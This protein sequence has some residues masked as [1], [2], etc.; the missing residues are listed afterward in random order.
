MSRLT[1][2]QILGITNNICDT[3]DASS[4][5][6]FIYFSSSMVYGDFSHTSIN[7]FHQKKPVDRYGALKY[8]SEVLIDNW[9]T[10]YD[11]NSIVIRPT[12]VYGPNDFKQRIVSKFLMQATTTGEMTI[13]GDGSSAL[14]FTYVDDVAN[15]AILA[16]DYEGSE[17]FNI[18]FGQSRSLLELSQLIAKA[19]PNAHPVC[20]QSSVYRIAKRGTLNSE[21]AHRLLGFEPAYSLETGLVETFKSDQSTENLRYNSK[22]FQSKL[23]IPLG[24]ADLLSSDFAELSHVL[25]TGWLTAGPMNTQFE[26]KMLGYLNANNHFAISLNSCASALTLALLAKNITGEVIVPAFTFSATVNAIILAGATPRF[27]DI[28]TDYLSLDINKIEACINDDTQAIMVVHLAGVIGDIEALQKIS[29]QHNLLLIE[30]CAQ[31]LG[32]E[33]NGQHAGTFGDISCFSFFPTKMI[34][35]GEGGMLVTDDADV[36]NTVRTLANHGYGSSTLDRERQRKPWLREQ[37]IAGFNFRMSN[38]NAALGV[39]QM[40]RIDDIVN[41]RRNKALAIIDQIKSIE[42]IRIFEYPDRKSVYQA[43]NILVADKIDRDAFTLSLRDKGVSASVHYPEVLPETKVF[44][45]FHQTGEAF[46]GATTIANNV[47]TIPLFGA[48]TKLQIA[49]MVDAIHAS[50][51]EQ[52]SCPKKADL[53]ILHRGQ[54]TAA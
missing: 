38:T 17:D 16:T 10:R 24:K 22:E 45:E 49:Y 14:D 34:T 41:T 30:D 50:I 51:K 35:T 15:A 5:E 37:L 9:C 47:V 11:V 40:N 20:N 53:K 44:R 29:K 28:E 18:S 43:L 23:S 39:A 7:E 27:V 12:A 8:A 21:K 4:L 3:L 6:K 25:Q 26:Q 52:R 36:A 19:V 1:F 32:A 31:A 46:T 33:N 2:E 42:D 13:V 54:S 48:L